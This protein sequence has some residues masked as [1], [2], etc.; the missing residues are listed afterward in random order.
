MGYHCADSVAGENLAKPKN[1]PVLNMDMIMACMENESSRRAV[2]ECPV[3]SVDS[4]IYVLCAVA[5]TWQSSV[6]IK[7]SKPDICGSV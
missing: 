4:L 6:N 7:F 1:A 5:V 2:I 3:G